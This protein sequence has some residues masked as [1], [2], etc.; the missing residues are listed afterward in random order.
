V[1]ARA[2]YREGV[3][4]ADVDLGQAERIRRTLPALAHRREDLFTA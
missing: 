4:V 1:L 2:G 3:V